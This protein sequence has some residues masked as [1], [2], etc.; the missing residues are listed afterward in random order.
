MLHV[1]LG[2]DAV[3]EDVRRASQ[4]GQSLYWIVPKKASDGDQAALFFASC[5]FVAL[6]SV[7]GTPAPDQFGRRN[8]YGTHVG[9]IVLLHK[10]VPLEEVARAMP[11]WAWTTYPRSYTT[12]DVPLSDKLLSLLQRKQSSS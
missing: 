1:L 4:T 8:V 3:L 5:G 12:I 6:G 2:Q 7:E 9:R 10:V 11:T